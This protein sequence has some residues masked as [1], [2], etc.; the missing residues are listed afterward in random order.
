MRVSEEVSAVLAAAE[1]S[2]KPVVVMPPPKYAKGCDNSVEPAWPDKIR[3]SAISPMLPGLAS[4]LEMICCTSE[5]LLLIRLFTSEVTL[6]TLLVC[7]SSAPSF[8]IRSR[9]TS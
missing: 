3:A 4:P 9:C 6:K 1:L 7:G 5:G 8:T 2:V